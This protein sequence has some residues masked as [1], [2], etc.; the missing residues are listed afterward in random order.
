LIFIRPKQN[1]EGVVERDKKE[2]KKKKQKKK[3]KTKKKKKKTQNM[4]GNER[5]RKMGR[6]CRLKRE[7]DR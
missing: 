4:P 5:R 6:V 7:G 1:A 2:K 3:K